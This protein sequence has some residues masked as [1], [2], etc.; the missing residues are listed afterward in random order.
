MDLVA[1]IADDFKKAMKSKDQDRLSA[2]RMIRSALQVKEK[3]GGGG[4]TEE[5]V[6]AVLKTL[7]KQRADAAEQFEQGGRPEMAARERAELALIKTYLPAEVDQAT[8][9]RVVAEVVAETGASSMKD[10]G[11]VMKECLDRLGAGADGKTVSGLV[12]QALSQ[13]S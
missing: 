2:L 12:R 8:M 7:A 1:R 13:A 6:L 4:L 10:M 5:S 9:A 3:D 11:P